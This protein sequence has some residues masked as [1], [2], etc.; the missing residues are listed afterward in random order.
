MEPYSQEGTRLLSG[1]IL[2]LPPQIP[3][4]CSGSQGL[5]PYVC[6]YCV[7]HWLCGE[8]GN[9]SM[10]L[11]PPI[12]GYWGTQRALVPKEKRRPRPRPREGS[13]DAKAQLELRLRNRQ[14]S[15]R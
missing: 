6:C 7:R 5:C 13:Q 3:S 9:Q 10:A 14:D 1:A 8:T 12:Q 4:F 11:P 2:T 15:G